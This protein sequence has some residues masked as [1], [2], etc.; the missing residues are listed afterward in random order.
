MHQYTLPVIGVFKFSSRYQFTVLAVEGMMANHK[1]PHMG[2]RKRRSKAEI[3]V[4]RGQ[5]GQEITAPA[6]NI[7]TVNTNC[8][9]QKLAVGKKRNCVN[10]HNRRT[11]SAY[12]CPACD[13]GLCPE[14]F[15]DYHRDR[16]LL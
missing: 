9:L 6:T 12:M 7:Q 2:I 16:E 8:K 15:V 5:N 10:K 14:C 13:V 4:A 1:P 3:N 11:R